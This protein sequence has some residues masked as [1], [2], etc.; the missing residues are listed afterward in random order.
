MSEILNERRKALEE[1]FFANQ[2]K[3]ALENLKAESQLAKATDELASY[4]TINNERVLQGLIQH[5]IGTETFVAIKLV[6]LVLVAWADNEIQEEERVKILSALSK[7]GA[8]QGSAVYDLVSG[9][10][11]NRPTDALQSSWIS[12]MKEY[13]PT[14][15]TDAKGA[16]KKEVLGS[17]TD[18]AESAGGWLF[19]W[20][21]VSSEE[22]EV[23]NQL[24]AV[25]S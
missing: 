21:A 14:L 25:F 4:T 15:D 9:W 23:L 12:F 10:L 20:G 19:G 18:V 1:Q 2:E 8:P 13:L 24:G 6:P 16:L 3:V 11:D 5:G 22:Q 7:H 17:S